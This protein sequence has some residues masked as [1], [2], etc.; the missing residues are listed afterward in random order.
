MI[1]FRKASVAWWYILAYGASLTEKYYG[2]DA[3]SSIVL[4][5]DFEQGKVNACQWENVDMEVLARL[6]Q[7]SPELVPVSAGSTGCS[8]FLSLVPSS[9]K[10]WSQSSGNSSIRKPRQMINRA[11]S[12]TVL[13][14]ISQVYRSTT[15]MW[16]KHIFRANYIH[17]KTVYMKLQW[18]STFNWF[19]TGFQKVTILFSLSPHL[20]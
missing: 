13:K 9:I 4:S 11:M 18:L 1:C 12:R 10:H 14:W 7:L 15:A 16:T 6:V 2:M 20:K 17:N 5:L 8:R 3:L 19:K